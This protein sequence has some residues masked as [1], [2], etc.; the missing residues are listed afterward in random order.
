[1]NDSMGA[2]SAQLDHVVGFQLGDIE[3]ALGPH[4]RA[5]FLAV[6]GLVVCTEFI[7]GVRN[8]TLGQLQGAHRRF[9]RGTQLM[10]AE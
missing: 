5:N 6:Q 4:A 10:G 1:M 9:T 3:R 7:G 2:L 8:G